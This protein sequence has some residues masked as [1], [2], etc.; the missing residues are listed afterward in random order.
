LLTIL[1]YSVQPAVDA[2]GNVLLWNGE[3]FGGS[4][5]PSGVPV[6]RPEEN[7]TDAVLE[8]LGAS[9]GGDQGDPEAVA[10]HVRR[11]LRPEE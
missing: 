9:G 4:L 3:V 8:A 6:P 1:P 7:D 11:V 5:G 2:A 10:L